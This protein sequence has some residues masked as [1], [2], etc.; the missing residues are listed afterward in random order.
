MVH[1]LIRNESERKRLYRRDSLGRLAERICAGE[2]FRKDAELG[3]M[4]CDDPF[5]T[6]LNRTYRRKDAATDVLAFG[7]AQ[8]PE[9]VP[10]RLPYSVL[11]DIVISL[12]T[13]ERRCAGDRAAMRKEVEL[14]FCH[15]LLHL[16]GYE[17]GDA[18]QRKRMA[19]RQAEYLDLSI[20]AVW[21]TARG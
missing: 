20:E 19:A 4:L 3:L 8:S 17:H 21:P 10:A 13:V 15:G 12:E 6:E 2:G 14:L 16:L 5:I 18:R 11:G 7:L 1:L 9:S